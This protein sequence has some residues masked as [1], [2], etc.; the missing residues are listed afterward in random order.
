MRT[1]PPLLP[2]TVVSIGANGVGLDRPVRVR[3]FLVRPRA[4][5]GAARIS[6][7]GFLLNKDTA[8]G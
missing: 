8:Q 6:A 3:R 1:L 5:D 2:I 4:R 7:G